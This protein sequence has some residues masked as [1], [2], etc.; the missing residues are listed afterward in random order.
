MATVRLNREA[1]AALLTEARRDFENAAH[2]ILGGDESQ[3]LRLDAC[4]EVI[5]RLNWNVDRLWPEVEQDGPFAPY[6]DP[7][8]K[9]ELS[10]RVIE[11]MRLDLEHLVPFIEDLESGDCLPNPGDIA[12]QVYL[13]HVLRGAIEQASEVTV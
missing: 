1:A 9:F 10:D 11:W 7:D 2:E 13:V 4:T 8:V 5:G 3:R 6:D 12:Q